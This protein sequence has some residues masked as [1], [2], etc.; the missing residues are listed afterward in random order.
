[1]KQ[2][3][4]LYRMNTIEL[5]GRYKDRVIDCAVLVWKQQALNNDEMAEKIIELSKK[6]DSIK[7]GEFIEIYRSYQ[8]KVFTF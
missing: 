4:S 1:M 2:H 6:L 5:K 8:K 3:D 7:K